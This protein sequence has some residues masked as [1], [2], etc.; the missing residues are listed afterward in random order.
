MGRFTGQC[1]PPV[2]IYPVR[3][4]V[5]EDLK[6]RL[7]TDLIPNKSGYLFKSRVYIKKPVINRST[8][9]IADDLMYRGPNDIFFKEFAI[10][11]LAFRYLLMSGLNLFELVGQFLF[12]MGY[13]VKCSSQIG[14]LFCKPPF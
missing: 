11:L 2:Y 12:G 9:L 14:I 4:S 6:N 3:L 13:P 10:L 8:G 5:R 1:D 7:I